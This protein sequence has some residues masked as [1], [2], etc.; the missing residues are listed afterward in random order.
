MKI[1]ILYLIF[2][3]TLKKFMKKLT[4]LLATATLIFIVACKDEGELTLTC[5]PG[6]AGT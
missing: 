3:K 2:A 6:H 1:S 5:E 4:L